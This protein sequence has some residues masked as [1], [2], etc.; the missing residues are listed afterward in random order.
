MRGIGLEGN[1]S[2]DFRNPWNSR[3]SCSKD[4]ITF[5]N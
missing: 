1:G 4:L 5:Q 3:N 2:D